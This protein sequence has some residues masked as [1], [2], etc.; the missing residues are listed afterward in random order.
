MT[1]LL[2]L[3]LGCQEYDA[4]A[5]VIRVEDAIER[6]LLREMLESKDTSAALSATDAASGDMSPADAAPASNPGSPEVDWMYTPP[7]HRVGGLSGST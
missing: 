4:C 7:G 3:R 1:G 5:Q 2:L 6:L